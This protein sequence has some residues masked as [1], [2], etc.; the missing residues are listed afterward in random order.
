MKI[1]VYIVGQ[2]RGTS[3][4]CSKYLKELFED[5]DTDYYIHTWESFNGKTITNDTGTDIMDYGSYTHTAEEIEKI[6]NSYPHVVSMKIGSTKQM[7][8]MRDLD[9]RLSSFPQFYCAYEANKYRRVYENM[10]GFRYD[11][12]VKIRPDIIFGP[13]NI[14]IFRKNMEYVK[15]NRLAVYSFYSTQ[16]IMKPDWNPVWDYY[17]I[18]SSFG[19][20]SMMEWVN[21]V[22]NND[23]AHKVFFSNYIIKHEL[24]SSPAHEGDDEPFIATPTIMR[25]LFKYNNFV[26]LFYENEVVGE[27]KPF[28]H[29]LYD[30]LYRNNPDREKFNDWFDWIEFKDEFLT[31]SNDDSTV[32]K[33]KE[34]ELENLANLIVE[35]YESEKNRYEIEFGISN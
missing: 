12:I 20:D 7:N 27:P 35:K 3:Y 23:G 24:V 14:R 4:D 21:D 9:S 34:T 26:D 19:M 2:W 17:T 22:V 29:F 13:E 8:E 31:Y 15:N 32:I 28:I 1:A 18:S 16:G 30:Y 33:Y 25:E 5:Y 11:V 6:R 10:N